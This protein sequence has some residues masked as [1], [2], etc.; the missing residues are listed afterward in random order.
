MSSISYLLSGQ[1]Y[2]NGISVGYGGNLNATNCTAVG[3]QALNANT[4]STQN[5]A[6]GYQ[7]LAATTTGNTN[8]AFG[9]QTMLANTSGNNNSAFGIQALYNCSGGS[10]NS[11]FGSSALGSN[12]T[13]GYNNAV[14]MQA[15]ST[16]TTG[17]YNNA[18]GSFTMIYNVT[19]NNN[20]AFGHNALQRHLVGD[21]HCAFGY[22]ALANDVSGT[23][24]NAFG[25]G[26][27]T[28]NQNGSNNNAFG[29]N[30]LIANTTGGN[31]NAFGFSA[32]NQ[33]TTGSGNSVLGSNA[34]ST[35][36]TGSYNVG[37][38]YN[39]S[40]T[41]VSDSYCTAIGANAKC[42]GN[43]STAIGYGAT[44]TGAG[45]IVIGTAN[46]LVLLKGTLGAANTAQI[47]VT[48]FTYNSTGFTTINPNTIAI[49]A[50]ASAGILGT[51]I[52]ASSDER[53]KTNILAVDSTDSLSKL[54]L[55]QPREYKLIDD[56]VHN[57]RNIYGFIAQ[58]VETVLPNAV[59]VHTDYIPNIFELADVSG[60]IITLRTKSTSIFAAD[61]SGNDASGNPICIRLF[62]SSN[63]ESH[64]NII[65]IIDDKT[66]QVDNPIDA[67][68]TFVYG[69]RINDFR[70]L[71]KDFIWTLTT[72]AV[73]ELDIIVQTQQQRIS[74]LESKLE[75]VLARL[76]AA[77]IA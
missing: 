41:G 26:A 37:V 23:F 38:G 19:S 9:F 77:G 14:G 27:L 32:L 35:N 28:Q 39:T 54:R 16:N 58:E 8:S 21:G 76:S 44:C 48:Y 3:Y 62:D 12:T 15:L 67:V 34:L 7:A 57:N 55:L 36:T 25:S 5:S 50:I 29:T 33:T 31:N 42:N 4:T 43:N 59:G 52:L 49:S 2:V 69:M 64:Q 72:S 73:K 11:A 60:N 68:E 18:F 66:F 10:S 6:F 30:T 53:I 46:E 61:A 45:Q 24:N 75:I 74:E 65:S 71:E 47:P 40:A 20:S 22:G 56:I 1:L 51:Y 17:I 13:G 63:N 70:A